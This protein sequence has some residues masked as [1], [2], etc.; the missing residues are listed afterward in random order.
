MQHCEMYLF[1]TS[2]HFSE[3]GMPVGKQSISAV[4]CF[5]V[6]VSSNRFTNFCQPWLNSNKS[7]V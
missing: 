1:L 5:H 7:Q 4:C 6:K 3:F 2:T